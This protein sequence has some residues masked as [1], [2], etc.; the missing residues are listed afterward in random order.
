MRACWR[1][2]AGPRHDARIRRRGAGRAAAACRHRHARGGPQR[3]AGPRE[4]RDRGGGAGGGLRGDARGQPGGGDVARASARALARRA[5]GAA[6]IGAAALPGFRRGEW[7]VAGAAPPPVRHRS[8]ERLHHLGPCRCEHGALRAPRLAPFRLL[9]VP[10]ERWRARALSMGLYAAQRPA[11]AHGVP[12]R[13]GRG[14][15]V[16]AHRRGAAGD[17]R[18]GGWHRG[19]PERGGHRRVRPGQG[20]PRALPAAGGR[21]AAAVRGRPAHAAQEPGHRAG[22]AGPGAGARGAGR[23]RQRRRQP[24]SAARPGTRA[25]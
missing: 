8:R 12:P 2:R 7:L 22:G 20:L 9:P 4:P 5:R 16:A 24:L 21:A 10:P 13:A 11:G 6:A 23:G 19:D 15:G 17:R 25:G 1:R 3:R 18:A 14:G